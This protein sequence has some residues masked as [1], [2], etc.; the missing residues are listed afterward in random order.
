[1]YTVYW[2][3][4]WCANCPETELWNRECFRYERLTSINNGYGGVI[5]IGYETPDEGWW[6]AWNYRVAQKNVS[7]GQSGGYRVAYSYTPNIGDRCYDNNSTY[8]CE[9]FQPGQQTGGAL[10]GY[11][12]VTET[13]KTVGDSPVAITSREFTLNDEANKDRRL[14]REWKTVYRDAPGT[15]QKMIT[16]TWTVAVVTY[17]GSLTETYFVYAQW[18]QEYLKEGS[19]LPANPQKKTFYD[20]E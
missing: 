15:A 7:D 12:A 10:V 2:N 17:T 1:G 5:T 19:G 9:Y 14:G 6:Q 13:L 3:K 4:G 11:R 18:V 20:Y 8:G 16:T